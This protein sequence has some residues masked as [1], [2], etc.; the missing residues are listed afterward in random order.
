[1]GVNFPE[2]TEGQKG[3]RIK[4]D[5]IASFNAM[6]NDPPAPPKGS[7]DPAKKGRKPAAVSA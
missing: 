4:A 5:D 3:A 6:L 1:L 7:T 2:L